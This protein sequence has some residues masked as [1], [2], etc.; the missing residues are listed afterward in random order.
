MR[1]PFL[2]LPTRIYGA[3]FGVVLAFA[4]ST[5]AAI[6]N[7]VTFRNFFDS[8]TFDRPVLFLQFPGRD[9]VYMIVQQSGAMIMV[10]HRANAWVKTR[11]DSISVGGV[12]GPTG[13][14]GG[15]LGF[16][17]HPN[18][19]QNRK[20]YVYYVA[21]YAV[22]PRPGKIMWEERTADT[23]GLK[24]SGAT[25][26]LVLTLTK[27]FI[28]HNGGTLKFGEDGMLYTAIGDGGFTSTADPESRAQNRGVLWGK[29]LRIDVDQ[30]D[31]YPADTMRNYAVPE[32]NPYT[33]S[34]SFLPEIWAYGLR[35]PWKWTFHP[36]THLIW[37]G[38]IG[39]NT[40]EELSVIPKGGNMGWK[41][42][43]GAHC[44][45]GGSSCET[46]GM[47]AP[48]LEL[49]RPQKAI[50]GGEFFMGDTT[51]A[52]HGMYFF[53]DHITNTV[54]ALRENAGVVAE[55]AVVGTVRKVVS[56][57]KDAQG[58]VFAVSMSSTTATVVSEN[59]GTIYVLESPDMRPES[60]PTQ[61]SRS[62][63]A[64]GP[65]ALSRR[66]FDRHR[67]RY[68]VFGLDGRERSTLPAGLFIVREKRG[69]TPPQILMNP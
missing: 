66:D 7:T 44:F 55:Y 17:F 49:A 12:N 62:V 47:T 53:G 46:N 54:W 10:E 1:L 22:A 42:W 48:I 9:S 30:P 68:Q 24:G 21:S 3:V 64:T 25:P 65:A 13:D 67:E 69:N 60:G 31:A 11:F 34:S 40:Y 51:A 5:T 6:P 20:Y 52:F 50:M 16:A 59:N 26:R 37:L 18:Y 35:S 19:A 43:E 63:R 4:G 41:V 33:S 23:S 61:I 14:D 38:D 56:F 57:D 39:H 8:T 29:M 36:K 27:P 28:Y 15:L 58:R 32:D 2:H 45:S